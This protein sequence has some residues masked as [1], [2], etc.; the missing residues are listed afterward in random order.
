LYI[1]AS[2]AIYEQKA[3]FGDYD[4]NFY[5]LDLINR[6]ISWKIPPGENSGAILGIPAA[7]RN[8]VVIGNEDKYLYCYNA[9][10]GNPIWKFRSN[11]R[12]TGSAVV[13]PA[14]VLFGSMDGNIYVLGLSDG[15]KLWSF[16]A[17]APISSSPAVT[18]G[19][20]YFLTED[21]RLL[22]FGIK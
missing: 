1:A 5:C 7:G 20:F 11:G 14:K 10:T 17:G 21:G 15:K 2:P 22:A 19:R 16:N 6:K 12:I 8:Y 18:N 4:G 13:S 9:A 3:Y